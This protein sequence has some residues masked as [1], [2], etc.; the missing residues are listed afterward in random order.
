M[1]DCWGDKIPLRGLFGGSGSDGLNEP[2]ICNEVIRLA[3]KT[4]FED[5]NV[6]Y[7]GTATYDRDGPRLRQTEG[8]P[9]LGVKFS[10]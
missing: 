5:I 3:N 7:L 9:N 4:P 2:E 8:S 6:L 10:L 1:A